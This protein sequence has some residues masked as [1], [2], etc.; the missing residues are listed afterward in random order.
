MF[1]LMMLYNKNNFLKEF[2]KN[3]KDSTN[4]YENIKENMYLV[5]N[6]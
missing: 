2:S 3:R 6:L 4:S 1:E 5:I